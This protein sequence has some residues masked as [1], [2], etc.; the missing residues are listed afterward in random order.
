[1]AALAHHP[2]EQAGEVA[3][4]GANVGDA[5][6][7]LKLGEGEDFGGMT[8]RIARDLLGGTQGVSDGALH[9]FGWRSGLGQDRRSGGEQQ[10]RQG[11]GE[12]TGL[13]RATS[14]KAGPHKARVRDG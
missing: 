11:G 1:M 2:R 12:K 13:H 6:A 5:L 9:Q 3:G 10:G 7:R 14:G 8:Q 4:A